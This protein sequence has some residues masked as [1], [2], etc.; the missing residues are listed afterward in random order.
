MY[1]LKYGVRLPFLDSSQDDL[2]IIFKTAG[3][4]FN[5]LSYCFLILLWAGKMYWQ[6]FMH[7]ITDDL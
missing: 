7:E 4:Q 2:H 5:V 6:E 1:V 3:K